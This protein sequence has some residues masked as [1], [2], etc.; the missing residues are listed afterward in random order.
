MVAYRGLYGYIYSP[1]HL[2]NRGNKMKFE[3][4]TNCECV[5]AY[6]VEAETAEDAKEKFF[7]GTYSNEEILDYKNETI[8]T[9]SEVIK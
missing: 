9:I 6:T 5:T 3:I 4:I 8:E 1:C 2:N 7:M